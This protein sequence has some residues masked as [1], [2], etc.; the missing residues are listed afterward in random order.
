MGKEMG[1]PDA[2]GLVLDELKFEWYSMQAM[3]KRRVNML[4]RNREEQ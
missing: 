1:S 2:I 3:C 4:R